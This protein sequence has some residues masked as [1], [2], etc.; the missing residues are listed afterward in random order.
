MFSHAAALDAADTTGYGAVEFLNRSNYYRANAFWASNNNPDGA[1]RVG[2]DKFCSDWEGYSFVA[3]P[4]L[5][6][7]N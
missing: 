3:V 6:I 5:E 7:P 4:V 1:W 2:G